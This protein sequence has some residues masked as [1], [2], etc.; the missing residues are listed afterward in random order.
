MSLIAKDKPQGAD[1]APIPAGMHHAVCYGVIDIGTQP[2]TGNFPARRKV[3]IM[4]EVPHELVE[5]EKDG[6]KK[7]MPRAISEK[8]TLS[9][10]E[11]GNLRPML[12][13]WRG[14][15]FTKEELDGF[16]LKNLVGANC[17][18]N[19]IHQNGRGDKAS[20]VYANVS[21]VNPL[22]KGMPKLKP[23]NETVIF[24]MD[25]FNGPITIPMNIPE[26]INALIVQ[27]KEF[28]EKAVTN[29]TV[30]P[31]HTGE[32]AGGMDDDIPF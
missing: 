5:I 30:P 16:D 8:Y 24:S 10:S 7:K 32:A 13:S 27:S 2:Q 3:L 17:F 23:L 15:P 4:W 12:Q 14:R 25:D 19:L 9:L 31:P 11:K 21:S 28:Q 1:F 26:W 20:R 18:L 6:I 29:P 22:A